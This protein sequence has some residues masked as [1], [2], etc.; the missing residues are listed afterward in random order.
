MNGGEKHVFWAGVLDERQLLRDANAEQQ[1]MSGVS[2]RRCGE[3]VR[4]GTN[5]GKR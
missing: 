4:L 1:G 5:E 2:F 3:W